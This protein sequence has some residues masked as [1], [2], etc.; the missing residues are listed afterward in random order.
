MI[1][2]MPQAVL[3]YLCA[4]VPLLVGLPLQLLQVNNID[5]FL[6]HDQ[7]GDDLNWVNLDD[8]NFNLWRSEEG[9]DFDSQVFD[10]DIPIPHLGGLKDKIREDYEF[11]RNSKKNLIEYQDEEINTKV[12][13]IV[14]EIKDTIFDYFIKPIP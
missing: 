10:A 12:V 5:Y 1:P 8:E 4:P 2:V 3:E 9:N 6:P 14:E 11:V 13:K 7:L